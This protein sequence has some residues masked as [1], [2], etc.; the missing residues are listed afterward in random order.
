MSRRDN[1]PQYDKYIGESVPQHK[2]Y[3]GGILPDTNN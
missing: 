1:I 2:K 3:V